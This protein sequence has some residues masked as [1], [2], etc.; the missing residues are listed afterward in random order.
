MNAGAAIYAGGKAESIA[1]GI[2][3][4]AEVIDN[5]EALKHLEAFIK[6]SNEHKA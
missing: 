1:D 5:G 3:K 6:S 2:K 4:A